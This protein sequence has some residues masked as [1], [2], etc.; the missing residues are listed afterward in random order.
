MNDVPSFLVVRI[1]GKNYEYVTVRAGYEPHALAV[2]K[3]NGKLTTVGR[4]PVQI[5]RHHVERFVFVFGSFDA[6]QC[7]HV[8]QL[9]DAH[10]FQQPIVAPVL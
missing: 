4:A 1:G 9:C 5:A 3:R 7:V 2:M 6:L 8:G 10:V